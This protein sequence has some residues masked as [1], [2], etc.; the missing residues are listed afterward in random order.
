MSNGRI[1][2][3]LNFSHCA[4]LYDLHTSI[5]KSSLANEQVYKKI[6]KEIRVIL[7]QI[8]AETLLF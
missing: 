2:P 3:R 1:Q 6:L 5:P 4:Y 7:Y 8:L